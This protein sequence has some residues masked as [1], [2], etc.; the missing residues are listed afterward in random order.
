[1]HEKGVQILKKD[2]KIKKDSLHYT[3][4]ANLTVVEKTGVLTYTNVD[5]Q[6]VGKEAQAV[7]E[8]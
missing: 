6:N 1:M 7:K 3:L 8:Q 2:V 4:L 5:L